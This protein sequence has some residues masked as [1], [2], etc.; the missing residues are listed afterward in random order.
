[1]I[2]VDYAANA[3][4]LGCV[5]FTARTAGRARA[6]RCD[7]ARACPRPAVIACH[8]E[9]EPAPSSGAWWD[10]GVPEVSGDREVVAAAERQRAG[11]AAQRYYG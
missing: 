9:P 4:S 8:V 10:L 2:D 5:A 3:E 7:A 1:M 6:T 11:A